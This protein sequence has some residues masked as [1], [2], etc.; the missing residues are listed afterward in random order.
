MPGVRSKEVKSS[1]DPKQMLQF[2]LEN[3]RVT[4]RNY[5]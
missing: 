1:K 2:A 3:E 4:I 5:R